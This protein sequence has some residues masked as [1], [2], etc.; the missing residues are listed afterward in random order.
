MK[1]PLAA[2]LVLAPSLVQ[3]LTLQTG[4]AAQLS[5]SDLAPV[6]SVARPDGYEVIVMAP[7]NVPA[8]VTARLELFEARNEP[9]KFSVTEHSSPFGGF[10]VSMRYPENFSFGDWQDREGRVLLT[11]LQGPLE[12]QSL[13]VSI[14]DNG[15][16]YRS[17]ALP[18]VV[19]EPST[20][21]LWGTGLLGVIVVAARKMRGQGGVAP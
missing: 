3:A 5:F 19:P 12:I 15:I 1:F 9:Y 18:S 17:I 13:R 11:V 4:D 8:G 14:F 21:V 7:S 16:E 2:L 20:L 6:G 10:G